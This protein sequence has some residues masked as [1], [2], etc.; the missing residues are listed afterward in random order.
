MITEFKQVGEQERVR[1]TL[2]TGRK[3]TAPVR[4]NDRAQQVLWIEAEEGYF[5]PIA[6]SE[7]HH[8][9]IPLPRNTR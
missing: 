1:F 3:F 2:K 6:Y 9:S 8:V 4:N 7:I 5:E